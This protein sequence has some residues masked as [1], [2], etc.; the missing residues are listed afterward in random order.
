[1][2]IPQ[3]S[4][5]A[6]RTSRTAL[7][8]SPASPRTRSADL[9]VLPEAKASTDLL[10]RRERRLIGPGRTLVAGPV[11]HD[12]VELDAVR[13]FMIRRRLLGLLQPLLAH[14]GA[15]KILIA[16][17]LDD[18]VALGDDTVLQHCLHAGSSVTQGWDRRPSDDRVCPMPV[19]RGILITAIL[20]YFKGR[21]SRQRQSRLGTT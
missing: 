15:R 7:L 10:H 12:V 16:L 8:P 5:G 9:D 1:M 21:S 4:D 11:D 13:A 18:V 2:D 20:A 6:P 3:E 19:E 17:A 14:R